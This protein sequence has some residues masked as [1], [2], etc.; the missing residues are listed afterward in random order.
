RAHEPQPPAVPLRGGEVV[1]RPARRRP[2][3]R[4]RP[5]RAPRPARPRPP[6][7]PCRP[8]APRPSRPQDLPRGDARRHR[9]RRRHADRRPRDGDG[10]LSLGLR[11]IGA[12]GVAVA[13]VGVAMLAVPG[14]TRGAVRVLLGV[15]MPE[16][17]MER[18]SAWLL[19]ALG[20]AVALV[21]RA[22]G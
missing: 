16:G 8:R 15:R 19:I 14:V 11:L 21:A 13:L 9:P 10:E 2:L 18:V 3:R 4:P 5:A 7:L 17:R 20:L 1:A 6:A 12:I 22:A